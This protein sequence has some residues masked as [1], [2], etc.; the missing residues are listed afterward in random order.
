MALAVLSMAMGCTAPP[1]VTAEPGQTPA[2]PS[3][4]TLSSALAELIPPVGT[5]LVVDHVRLTGSPVAGTLAEHL[6]GLLGE[7]ASGLPGVTVVSQHS[8]DAILA[9][10][11]TWTSDLYDLESL[12]ALGHLQGAQH[13]LRSSFVEL[14]NPPRIRLSLEL[15]AIETGTAKLTSVEISRASLPAALSAEPSNRQRIAATLD[16]WSR[17]VPTSAFRVDL[18]TDRGVGASFAPGDPIRVFVRSEQAGRVALDW[19]DAEGVSS[20]FFPNAMHED[21]RIGAVGVLEIPDD[22]MGFDLWVSEGDGSEVL[23]AVVTSD[24][25]SAAQALCGFRIAPH[26]R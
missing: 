23:R 7:A 18:W 21:D 4:Q 12:P 3:V 13:L 24:D 19:L 20:R 1:P 25:G 9:L 15:V 5:T 22:T 8:Q 17:E 2:S 14:A 10:L 11:V 6:H 26:V 16:T